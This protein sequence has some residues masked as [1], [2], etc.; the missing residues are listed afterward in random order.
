MFVR[1][2]PKILDKIATDTVIAKK[3]INRWVDNLYE[4][5]EWIKEKKSGFTQN[6]LERNFPIFKNLDY[7]E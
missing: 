2:D 7:A 3:S 5:A 6:E 1:S 4:V